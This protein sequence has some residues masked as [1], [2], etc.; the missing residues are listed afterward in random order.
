MTDDLEDFE[1][2]AADYVLGTLDEAERHRAAALTESDPAFA[3]LVDAWSRR[4]API[5]AAIPPVE[6]PPQLWQRIEAALPRQAAAQA[7]ITSGETL[8]DRIGFWR[9]WSLG[10]SAA[11]AALAFYVATTELG[12]KAEDRFVAV[13]NSGDQQP[14]WLV[15]VDVKAGNLTIRPLLDVA[16]ANQDYELWIITGPETPPRS[17]GL[18]DQDRELAIPISLD[19]RQAAAKVPALAV[20]LE[21]AGGSTTGLPTGPVLFQGALLSLESPGN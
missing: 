2:L 15:T 11:A 7:R 3:R 4:L 19:V 20:S 17:L 12:P 21:P 1:A 10:A 6:P 9:W 18:L 8:W 16:A 5:Q 14:A 13:L